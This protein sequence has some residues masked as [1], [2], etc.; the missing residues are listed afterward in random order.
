MTAAAPP[1]NPGQHAPIPREIWIL[2]GAAFVIAIGFGLVSPVLPAY[3]Q[4]FNVGVTAAS[5]VVSI[6][7]FFRLV[8]APAGGVLI[9]KLGER[10]IYLSG[11]LIVAISSFATAFA[12]T[13]WQLLAF[14]GL[15]GIGSTMF[16]VSSMALLVRLA[17]PE[18]RGKTSSAYSSSFLIGS[19]LGPVLGGLLAGWGLRAPFIVYGVALVIAAAVVLIGLGG[20]RL[21][22]VDASAAA[23]PMLLG[24]ALANPAYRA[25]LVSGVAH[26]W[27]NFGAR[28]ALL[29]LLAVAV[30]DETW[31]AGSALAIGAAGTAATLQ[32]S[33]RLADRIGRRPLIMT[34]LAIMALTVGALGLALH[35]S[36]GVS[37]GLAVLFGLCLVSG[38]G[39][40][41]VG[42]A[43]QAAVA[44]I[45][46]RDR[47][48]GK[49]LAT[50]QMSQD[51]GTIIGPI[52]IGMVA[53]LLG[54]GVAFALCGVVC[55]IG[56]MPW[57]RAPDT[58]G[59]TMGSM[60]RLKGPID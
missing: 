57:L 56:L 10:K 41:L 26:G 28:T 33:G 53:D 47:S 42:P 17:P 45:V 1:T 35:P 37:T 6:F 44:D 29:P 34:G 15:G 59:G 20:A 39:A 23:P 24:Q 36:L 55:L 49:V 12:Q 9:E 51:I 3:A 22:E 19:M 43:T 38:V 31:V 11:L 14:R 40:G 21:R 50:F 58:L 48:G 8:F 52:L 18:A 30:L 25:V 60:V 32:V 5:V 7:A 54:F 46:G 2:I 27:V 13:Y 4:S 16:T